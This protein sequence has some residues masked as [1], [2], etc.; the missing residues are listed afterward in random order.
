A[1][2]EPYTNANNNSTSSIDS[3]FTNRHYFQIS[4]DNAGNLLRSNSNGAF[5]L[6]PDAY[7]IQSDDLLTTEPTTALN[8][9]VVNNSSNKVYRY[10]SMYIAAVDFNP[11]TLTPIYSSPA[12]INIFLLPVF[13][14]IAVTGITLPPPTAPANPVCQLN[15]VITPS[16]A[17]DKSIIWTMVPDDVASIDEFG[18]VS[19]LVA[20]G[21]TRITARTND[22]GFTAS[23]EVT[24]TGKAVL[25]ILFA[26]EGTA[27]TVSRDGTIQ[28]NATPLPSD[29]A[30][31]TLI[32]ESSDTTK[33]TVIPSG[34]VTGVAVGQAT[35]SVRPQY[36]SSTLQKFC[37]VTVT[38]P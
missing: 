9:D 30:N 12:F 11:Q 36:G 31:P 16:N 29:A 27:I 8:Y 34:V 24:L 20:G 6:K 10:A 33:A 2:F 4:Y 18:L 15:P 13:T 19:S 21:T 37:T 5:I 32:W 22:G 3:L 7:F 35:I 25:D 38:A 23:C 28:L 17:S 1:A 14:R 26:E